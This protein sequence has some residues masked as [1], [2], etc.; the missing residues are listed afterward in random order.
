[1]QPTVQSEQDKMVPID[2]SGDP[3]EVEVKEEE[4]VNESPEI[5]IQE[6][7][8]T[9]T[10][11]EELEDYSQSV[12]RRID[13]LTRKM[14]EAERREQAAIDYAKKVQEQQKILAA[15]V[16]QRD[17]QWI[18]E[19]EKKL[20]AQEEFAK[21]ALQAA[22]QENDTEKQVEA[23]Q[24]ISNMAVERQ[25]L[26]TQK[27]QVEAEPEEQP[28]PILEQPANNEPKPPSDKANKW[29]E[30]NPWFNNDKVMTS[31]AMVIHGDLV[32]EGFDVESDDYYN[33]ISQRI[34]TRF[35]QEF[36]DDKP[37]PTQKVASAVRTSSTG[38]RTVKLTPSQVAIA[39]KLGVPLEEYAKH[40][41]EGA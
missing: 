12:K 8:V 40:V 22:I 5:E 31:A 34:R 16:K 32:Q 29:A 6:G 30:A 39:K 24:A 37:R 1:M 27:L 25:N 2:T 9:E 3:V 28:A 33:E 11:K 19:T 13:K 15:Q 7:Q 4:K 35:P 21:R 10:K 41:K 18:G 38:R 17:T 20:D 14:R 36:G 23:Q 26:A